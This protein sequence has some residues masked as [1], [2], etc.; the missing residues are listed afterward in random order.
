MVPGDRSCLAEDKKQRPDDEDFS[1]LYAR[2]SD[3]FGS[4]VPKAERTREYTIS[5]ADLAK[6]R[7]E[8]IRMLETIIPSNNK[9]DVAHV[10]SD[11]DIARTLSSW[12]QGTCLPLPNHAILPALTTV[13]RDQVGGPSIHHGKQ[14]GRVQAA[15]S[16]DLRLRAVRR[17]AGIQ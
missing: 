12:K 10:V 15:D 6:R 3:K 11:E 4:T 8:T 16:S 5:K 2:T 1:F 13:R 17:R 7:R 9:G 14:P